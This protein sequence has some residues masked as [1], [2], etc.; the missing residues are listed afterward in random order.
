MTV[1]SKLI[2]AFAVLHG[3]RAMPIDPPPMPVNR[4]SLETLTFDCT[5]STLGDMTGKPHAG[6]MTC[7]KILTT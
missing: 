6:S 4:D 1:L 2:Y 7:F 5:R 3:I